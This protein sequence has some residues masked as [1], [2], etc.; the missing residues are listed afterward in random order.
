MAIFKKI[1]DSNNTKMPA[2]DDATELLEK[3]MQLSV[4]LVIRSREMMKRL[5]IVLVNVLVCLL[6]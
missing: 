3:G 5:L 2:I 1:A 6:L 4:R